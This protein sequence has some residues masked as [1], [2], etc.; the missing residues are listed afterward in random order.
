LADAVGVVVGVG[1]GGAVGVAVGGAVGVA[2]GVAVGGA[3]VKSW[4]DTV[5][6]SALVEL[7]AIGVSWGLC[8]TSAWVFSSWL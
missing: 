6:R 1:V 2:V 4:V 5:D 7:S 3:V 8:M